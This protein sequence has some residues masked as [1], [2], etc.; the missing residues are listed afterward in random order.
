MGKKKKDKENEFGL[1]KRHYLKGL[2][3]LQK[4]LGS[5]EQILYPL[6]HLLLYSERKKLNKILLT[7]LT[8]A[9]HDYLNQLQSQERQ[10]ELKQFLVTNFKLFSLESLR[11]ITQGFSFEYSD[12]KWLLTQLKLSLNDKSNFKSSQKNISKFT[13]V[14][15]I[16]NNCG[17]WKEFDFIYLINISQQ[18]K[19]TA[20]LADIVLEDK[21]LSLLLLKHL[22]PNFNK[23]QMKKIIL[24]HQLNP[25]LYPK[26][27][28]EMR[29][30]YLYHLNKTF[31]P[32]K[33]EE[34]FQSDPDDL[35]FYLNFLEQNKKFGELNSV[36][37]R[38][39]G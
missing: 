28:N 17:L 15:R 4:E 13:C 12:Y 14:C 16:I 6:F 21:S 19:A 10:N 2:L 22:K 29:R 34:F 30:G 39:K 3:T 38:I 37:T 8:A 5:D 23:A 31:G 9:Y 27:L 11:I 20:H 35:A 33:V 32:E 26:L 25:K 1:L 36:I 7:S 24:K 18:L